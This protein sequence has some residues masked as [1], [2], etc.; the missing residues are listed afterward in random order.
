VPAPTAQEAIRY[1]L[2][3]FRAGDFDDP[4]TADANYLRR[5]DAELFARTAAPAGATP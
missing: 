4:A 2:P 1:A 3:R 5:S